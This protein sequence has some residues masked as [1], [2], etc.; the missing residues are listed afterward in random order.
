M[1]QSRK[2]VIAIKEQKVKFSIEDLKLEDY[3]DDEFA[4]ANVTF[5][6]TSKNQHKLIITE[7]VLRENAKSVLGKWLV[8]E[9]DKFY[10]DVT[11]HTDSQQIFGYFPP[12]QEVVFMK[13]GDIVKA[14][15]NVIISKIYSK[16]LCDLFAD[17]KTRKDVSVEMLVNGDEHDDGS[18]DVDSFRIVGVT[19]LGKALGREVH[20]SCPDA[21]MNMVRFSMEDANRFYESHNNSLAELQRFSKERRKNMADIK[22]KIN[23]TELKDTPW[24]DVDKTEMRN[25]IMEAS[26][27]ATLVKSVYMLVE[28]GWKD[29]SSE[30]LKYPVMELIDDT[31]YYNRYGLASA[32][33]YAKQEN[34]DAVVSKIEKIYDK[35]DLDKEKKE[36]M[37]MKEIEFAVV[38]LNDM[39]CKVYNAIREKHEWGFYIDG[40]YEEDNQ[41]FAIIKDDAYNIYRIDYSYTEDGLTLAEEYQKVAVEFVPTEEMKKF[42]KPENAEK[43]T[44][45]ADDDEKDDEHDDGDDE[46]KGMS[47]EEKLADITS[48]CEELKKLLEDKE[49]IIMEQTTE[50]EDLRKFKNDAEEKEKMT[51]IDEVMCDVEKFLSS[52][53]YNEFKSEGVTCELSAIENWEN[54]VKAFC[55]SSVTN[56]DDTNLTLR[57]TNPVNME[58]KNN[59]VWDRL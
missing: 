17:E 36:D 27:K 24:G 5:L 53:Q 25:K 40:L 49:N 3:N 21:E 52:D 4:I 55:F 6:S 7:E 59:S 42:A 41:K 15:A 45:F 22:Y 48:Q 57:M 13:D 20:G 12:N 39:W 44:K 58:D 56:Q 38:N 43:Y 2:V 10:N 34:E 31:F 46:K 30:H 28:D 26:N 33:A 29:A 23:K 11:T 32:L 16:Q 18:T 8:G 35:F 51:K 9:Y 47:D 19:V 14:S 37:A 50:L 54:K 1:K